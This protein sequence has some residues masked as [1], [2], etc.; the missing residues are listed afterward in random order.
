[1]GADDFA[2]PSA[3]DDV[4]LVVATVP[5]ALAALAASIY[6]VAPTHVAHAS[7]PHVGDVVVDPFA[8]PV[9]VVATDDVVPTLLLLL[10]ILLLLLLLPS[11]VMLMLMLL[12]L[13]LA[14]TYEVVF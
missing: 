13:L 12:L 8:T 11:L 9:H 1:M 14:M 5:A 2:A 4:D 6:V 3:A 7:V 10:P